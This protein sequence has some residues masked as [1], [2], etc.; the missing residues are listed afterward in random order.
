M[1]EFCILSSGSRANCI[2]VGTSR[3][4]I[5][6]DCGL[7][8]RE[9]AKRLTAIGI[10]PHSIDAILVTHEHS[11]HINGIPVLAKKLS[12][13]VYLNRGTFESARLFQKTG[14][15]NTIEIETGCSFEVGDL[16]VDPFTIPHDASDPVM[17][18]FRANGHSLAV[19]TDIGQVTNLVREKSRGVDALVIESNHDPELLQEAPYPWE[20]KQRIAGRHGHLSNQGAAELVRELSA[21]VSNQMRVLIGA[22]VSENSNHPELVLDSL[23][24]AWSGPVWPRILAADA[25]TPTPRFNLAE[26]IAEDIEPVRRVLNYEF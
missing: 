7:S 14:L 24:A 18:K 6:I 1:L 11:D 4:R 23:N 25:F 3:T 10:D 26:V 17:F 19:I 22:H 15:E 5:L 13:P 2:Y 20:L 16:N 21:E 8:A 12:V 9:A